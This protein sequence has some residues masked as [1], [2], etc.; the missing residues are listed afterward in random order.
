MSKTGWLLAAGVIGAGVVGA[1]LYAGHKR[2]QPFTYVPA[3][4]GASLL[5]KTARTGK[6]PPLVGE[7]R[8]GGMKVSHY[9]TEGEMSINDRVRLIQEHVWKGIQD[10][11]MRKIAIE[12]T[13]SC[14]ERDGACEAK[15]LYKAIKRRVR[16]ASFCR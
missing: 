1:A 12:A 14:P 3:R 10:P 8:A 15:A 4:R 9:R 6:M 5:G 7:T 16:S 11:R 2:S 13:R